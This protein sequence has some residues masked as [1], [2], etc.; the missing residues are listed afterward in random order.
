MERLIE[1][2]TDEEAVIV[3]CFAGSGSTLV[4]AQHLG[5]HF[6]GCDNGVNKRTGQTWADVANVRL[7]EPFTPMMFPETTQ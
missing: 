3:D 5:R 4:A 7:A 6:Y 2:Y 1:T